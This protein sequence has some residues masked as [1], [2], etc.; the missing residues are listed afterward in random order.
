[1]FTSSCAKE[2]QTHL[3]NTHCLNLPHLK[4]L[5]Q[6]HIP[7]K[8]LPRWPRDSPCSKFRL[9]FLKEKLPYYSGQRF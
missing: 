2:L 9:Y 3:Q 4:G 5:L 1:M 7:G 8:G 6:I